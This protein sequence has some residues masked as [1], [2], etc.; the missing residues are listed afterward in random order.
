MNKTIKTAL[1]LSFIGWLGFCQNLL[2][3]ETINPPE[4]NKPQ[5]VIALGG[6][7][8]EIIYAIQAQQQLVAVDTTS[9]W[10]EA[11]SLLP[12]VGYFR[13]LSAE[14]ILSL[15]PDL[16]LMSAEAGPPAVI[17]QLKTVNIPIIQVPSGKSV[18]AVLSKIKTIASAVKETKRG[19]A[20]IQQLKETFNKLESLKPQIKTKPRVVFLFS[21]AKGNLLAAGTGTAADAMI[22][23]ASGENVFNQYSGYKP[24]NSEVLIAAAPDILLLTDRVLNSFGGIEKLMAFPGIP[25][26][27]AGKN[28]RIVIMDT[29]YLLGFGP[30]TAEAALDLSYQFHP[31]LSL[32]KVSE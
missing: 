17:E 16:L 28:K 18:A 32:D 20:L 8:T 14:G 27:P 30:R 6:D 13:A 22:K 29:L 24:V 26:T 7:I 9:Y 25:L 3:L 15:S 5:R 10:P 11:A 21:V 2:A 23:L 1:I 31:E 12:K 4:T 19:D